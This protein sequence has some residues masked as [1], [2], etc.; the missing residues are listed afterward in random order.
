M[1]ME[2]Y[3]FICD[4]GLTSLRILQ[5]NPFD[6]AQSLKGFRVQVRCTDCVAACDVEAESWAGLIRLFTNDYERCGSAAWISPAGEW[7]LQLE[8]DNGG[9]FRFT[10]EI[11]S[12]LDFHCWVL[13]TRFSMSA[14]RFD[15]ASRGVLE[16][17]GAME[18]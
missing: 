13:Q 8:R 16:F 17:L 12:L 2:Y 14:D 1:L 10:S 15:A 9:V 6:A 4:E 11:N 3:D 5:R 7:K 18:R